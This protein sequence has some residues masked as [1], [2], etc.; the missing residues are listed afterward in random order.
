MRVPQPLHGYIGDETSLI[1]YDSGQLVIH[2]RNCFSQAMER[3]AEVTEQKVS[4]LEARSDVEKE[5]SV[6]SDSLCKIGNDRKVGL[7]PLPVIVEMKV[8]RDS[9]LNM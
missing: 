2:H 4:Q 9:P 7:S 1:P 3:K 6:F 8:Y 5:R